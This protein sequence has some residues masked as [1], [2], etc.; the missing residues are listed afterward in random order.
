MAASDPLPEEI[1]P[2]VQ[3]QKTWQRDIPYKVNSLSQ[4]PVIVVQNVFD[5]VKLRQEGLCDAWL[6]HTLLKTG[7]FSSDRDVTHRSNFLR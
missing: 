1:R 6:G 3:F 4:I 2:M 7:L 5:S